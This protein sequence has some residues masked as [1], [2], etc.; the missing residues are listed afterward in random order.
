MNLDKIE[1][2]RKVID[3]L[4]EKSFE[5]DK[6]FL[7]DDE[8]YDDWLSNME[9][10]S[11]LISLSKMFRAEQIFLEMLE[12]MES[13]PSNS[14]E[15]KIFMS[16]AAGALN[17]YIEEIVFDMLQYS[18]G[19]LKDWHFKTTVGKRFHRSAEKKL[20]ELLDKYH[21]LYFFEEA[22]DSD[23]EVNFD[24][25][26][27]RLITMIKFFKRGTQVD[28]NL[29]KSDTKNPDD[30]WSL[31]VIMEKLTAVIDAI[32]TEMLFEEALNDM[33]DIKDESK[34][35]SK[36]FFTPFAQRSETFMKDILIRRIERLVDF[37]NRHFT[38]PNVMKFQSDLSG[39]LVTL[40]KKYAEIYHI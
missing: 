23:F 36:K 34:R 2:R 25:V 14:V 17:H 27:D 39:A 40:R 24:T 4:V 18:H 7:N 37:A 22:D 35:T 16:M 19:A 29:R 13:F 8:N 20:H 3:D 15:K 5:L 33:L 32:R 21:E 38:N 9:I 30:I 6:Q 1:R 11:N 10:M 12:A 26:T 28:S 31:M